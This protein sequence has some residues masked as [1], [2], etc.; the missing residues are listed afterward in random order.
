[1]SQSKIVFSNGEELLLSKGDVLVSV[2]SYELDG[3][4]FC[5]MDS[6]TVLE[7]SMHDGL[8]PSILK[9]VLSSPYFYGPDG[10]SAIYNSS[11]IVKIEN[12]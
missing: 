5:S 6:S 4:S 3:E 9:V 10:I 2:N 8:I 1:M 12:L 11:S 7:S